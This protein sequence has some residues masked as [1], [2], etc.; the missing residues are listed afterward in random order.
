MRRSTVLR[1]SFQIV[2][3]GGT[4]HDKKGEQMA[5]NRWLKQ[6]DEMISWT[7]K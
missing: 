4:V 3:P 7:S 2:F 6:T 5:R 1:L